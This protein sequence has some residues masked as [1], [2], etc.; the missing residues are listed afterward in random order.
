MFTFQL[1]FLH[2]LGRTNYKKTNRIYCIL[3]TTKDGRQLGSFF[4]VVILVQSHIIL[5]FWTKGTKAGPVILHLYQKDPKITKKS[6]RSV[7]K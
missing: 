6:H 4:K 7:K 3:K 2:I 1:T 5:C